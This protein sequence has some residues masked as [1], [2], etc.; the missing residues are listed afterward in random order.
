MNRVG[1]RHR[2]AR[3]ID[4]DDQSGNGFILLGF[5]ELFLDPGQ[6][7]HLFSENRSPGLFLLRYESRDV[8]QEDL[9]AAFSFDHFFPE[10]LCR[11]IE[12]NI[13]KSA[14]G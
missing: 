12:G 6:E 5:L 10:R 2:S 8:D 11:G 7:G 14:A 3:R 4:L 9:R 13:D 1:R